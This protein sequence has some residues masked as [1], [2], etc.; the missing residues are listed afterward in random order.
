MAN[1]KPWLQGPL[2]LSKESCRFELPMDVHIL[3]KISLLQYLTNY[4]VVCSRRQQLYKQSFHKADKDRDG[5][6]NTHELTETLI[7]V[8]YVQPDAKKCLQEI[9]DMIRKE[10]S[11]DGEKKDLMVNF[12]CFKGIGAFLERMICWKMDKQSISD[13]VGWSHSNQRNALESTD[14]D[15]LKWKLKGCKI[16]DNLMTVFHYL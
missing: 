11:P 16:N 15:G 14:F 5:L 13:G 2:A 9:I 1:A 10:E 6:L 8:I 4:C 12:Q 3:E 7:N